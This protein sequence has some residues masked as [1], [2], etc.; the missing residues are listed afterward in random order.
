M[1]I[2][3]EDAVPTANDIEALFSSGTL[4][5]FRDGAALTR[6]WRCRKW[7]AKWVSDTLGAH[8]VEVSHKDRC[9]NKMSRESISLKHF[10]QHHDDRSWRPEST[11]PYVDNMD[12]MTLAPELRAE[13]PSQT[14]FGPHRS[15]VIY[16]GFLGPAGSSTRLHIDSE[17]N[18]ITCVFGRKLFILLPPSAQDLVNYDARDIPL[19]DPWDP[20]IERKVRHHP[21]FRRCAA[22]VHV[23]VLGAGDLLVQPRGWLHWVVNLELSFSVACWAK[24]CPPPGEACL[25]SEAAW[26]GHQ[27]ESV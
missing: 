15:L 11:T 22:A 12:L 4:A 10:L 19:Q 5:V 26:V 25:D 14:L 21:M 27:A 16:S 24:A 20:E 13:C 9:G 3:D 17:D 2:A 23:L 18:L 6:G 1:P 8:E 7:D